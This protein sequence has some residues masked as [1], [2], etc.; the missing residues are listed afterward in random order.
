[1][2]SEGIFMDPQMVE[3]VLRWE[4][5]TMVIEIR[6]FLGLAGYC[7]RFIKEFSIIATP[8]T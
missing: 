8:L 4:K 2:S 6:S 1:M 5:P 3:A 7:K